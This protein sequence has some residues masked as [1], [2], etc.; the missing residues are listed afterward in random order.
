MHPDNQPNGDP[1]FR[2]ANTPADPPPASEQPRP[3]AVPLP[4]A[5]PSPWQGS[6]PSAQPQRP[7]V[8]A[9]PPAGQPTPPAPAPGSAPRFAPPTPQKKSLSSKLSPKGFRPLAGIAAFIAIVVVTA[10]LLNAF[11]F[12][13]YFV[14]GTSMTPTLHNDDR[15]II[16]K[17]EKTVARNEQIIK[18]VVGLPG[19]TVEF[20][21]GRVIV[22]N[23]QQPNGF[24]ANELLGL[25]LASTYFEGNA[26]SFT[27]PEGSVFVLGDNRAPGGSYDSRYFGPVDTDKIVGRLWL[28]ILPLTQVEAY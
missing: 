25:D 10:A 27:V 4:P 5:P 16:S 3:G 28:R 13:S 14:Q 20:S 22:K 15:L 19:E 2:A 6:T 26:R 7:M 17:V 1:N 11:I 12:Q 9:A 21:N 8:A 23:A 24:D 18:R